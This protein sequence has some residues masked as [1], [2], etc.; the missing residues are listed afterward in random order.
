MDMNM[1]N[2]DMGM[3]IMGSAT[4][5]DL[6]GWSLFALLLSYFSF[7]SVLNLPPYVTFILCVAA[8]RVHPY[9]RP[10][11]WHVK[12]TTTLPVRSFLAR[13]I[14]WHSHGICIACGCHF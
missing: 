9:H 13:D 14:L 3:V 5:N 10:V 11:Q 1:M 6:I 2:T 12:D 4:I 7:D 8:L